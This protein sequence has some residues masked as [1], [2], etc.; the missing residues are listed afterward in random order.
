MIDQLSRAGTETQ[1]IALIRNLDRTR[2]RPFLCLLN[3]EDPLSRSLE[4][5][6]CPAVRLGVRSLHHPMTL[7]KAF[8]LARFLRRHRIDV[9]QV[10]FPDSTYLGVPVARLA[11]VRRIVR[12]RNN[13]GYWMTPFHRWLGRFC[14]HWTDVV[15]ANCEACRDA[16]IADEGASPR[17]VLVLENGVDL[18]RFARSVRRPCPGT[19][20]GP[21]IGVVA[22]L[23][24]V[25]D[26]GLFLRAAAQV[27]SRHGG[28]T[29][30]IAGEGDQR[31][32]LERQADELG[33]GNRLF[34]PGSVKDIPAFLGSLD[35]A[36][37]CSRSE[38]MSNALLEYMAAGRPIV[39]TAVG[40]NGQLIEHGVHGL[41][42]PPGD[43]GRLARAI[44]RLLEDRELAARLGAAARRRVQEEYSRETMIRRFEAFYE[45]LADDHEL[46]DLRR[47]P[48]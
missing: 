34:L 23:R 37:L 8:R 15:V 14:N 5:P 7:V 40:A 10:Y 28:A 25:K 9:L 1:L 43:P 20:G 19:A 29:F 22:N 47:I 41:L 46:A 17:R 35:V 4:P 39:A 31:T 11:G 42:V 26:L 48:R 13:L 24:P 32:E 36:V 16:V 6:D 30:H 45:A 12:T 3:G 21:R 18:A 44:R 2:V 38:G 27:G 33:L